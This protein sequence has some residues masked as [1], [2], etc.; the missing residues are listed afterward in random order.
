MIQ[1]FWMQELQTKCKSNVHYI[2]P[3]LKDST[4]F[5]FSSSLADPLP[6][7]MQQKGLEHLMLLLDEWSGYA[8]Y[9]YSI[10]PSI[11]PF[12]SH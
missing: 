7:T 11:L 5:H 1:K 8:S 6:T 4:K 9:I 12:Y 10:A 2:N 3:T